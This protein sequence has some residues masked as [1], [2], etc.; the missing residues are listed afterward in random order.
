[1]CYSPPPPPLTM[2][3]TA[4]P[5]GIISPLPKSITQTQQPHQNISTNSDDTPPE[6][7][8]IFDYRIWSIVNLV[9]GAIIIGIPGFILST[10]T[11]R[12]KQKGNFARAKRFS[13]ITVGVNIFVSFLYMCGLVGLLT[14]INNPF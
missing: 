1:M 12:Y 3:P 9:F 10:I 14:Y 11:R 2:H 8:D 6:T 7:A 5:S 4:P 13:S